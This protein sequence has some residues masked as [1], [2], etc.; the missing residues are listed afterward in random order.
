MLAIFRN[1]CQLI[2]E[3]DLGFGVLIYHLCGAEG[4]GSHER[5]GEGS[6]D[7]KNKVNS[8]RPNSVIV[9]STRTWPSFKTL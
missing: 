5:G 2:E 9:A 3:M 1:K 4:V 6:W 7:E 8:G